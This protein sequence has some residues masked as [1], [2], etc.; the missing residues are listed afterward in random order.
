MRLMDRMGIWRGPDCVSIAL[1]FLIAVDATGGRYTR[2]VSYNVNQVPL[3]LIE[4]LISRREPLHN[5]LDDLMLR[6]LQP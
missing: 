1:L 3:T 6:G 2:Y 5:N 4:T